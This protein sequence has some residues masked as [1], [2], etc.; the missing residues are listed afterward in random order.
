MS[1]SAELTRR[2]MKTPDT[3]QVVGGSAAAWIASHRRQVGLG[4]GAV[5][6]LVVAAVTVGVLR[7]RRADA[8]GALLAD[9]YLAAGGELSAVPLPGVAGP[10]YADDAARQRAVI[11]AAAKVRAQYPGGRAAA[12]AAL[13]EGD[14]HLRLG[15]LDPA[16]AAYQAYLE[17]ARRDDSLRFGALEG[18][19][20]VAEERGRIDD[21]LSGWARLAA[22]VPALADRADLERARLLAGAGRRDEARKLL[23]GFGAAHKGS[24]LAADAASRLAELGGR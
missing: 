12:G 11:D 23:E 22:E 1:K 20:I 13:A 8:A 5:A 7:A 17:G 21:A 6:I 3:F 18:L 19:A 10:F 14:A 24:G 2:D 9:V 4:A 15:E 16:A